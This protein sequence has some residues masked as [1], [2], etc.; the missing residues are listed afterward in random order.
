MSPASIW[1]PSSHLESP[2]RRPVRQDS[3]WLLA[4]AS[5]AEAP[6]NR[7]QRP[8][9]PRIGRELLEFY[10]VGQPVRCPNSGRLPPRGERALDS[11]VPGNSPLSTDAGAKSLASQ[12]AHVGLGPTGLEFL[13]MIPEPATCFRL[14]SEHDKMSN[15]KIEYDNQMTKMSVLCRVMVVSSNGHLCNLLWFFEFQLQQLGILSKCTHSEL[16]HPSFA[17]ICVQPNEF[18]PVLCSRGR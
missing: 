15:C 1:V 18:I 11:T 7:P 9:A 12:Q 14:N 2:P 6:Q 5:R 16:A 8:P 10:S 4:F 3:R 13:L 17:L